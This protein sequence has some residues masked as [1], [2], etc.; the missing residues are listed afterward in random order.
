MIK[1]KFIFAIETHQEL[2]ADSNAARSDICSKHHLNRDR[3]R[4]LSFHDIIKES[5]AQKSRKNKF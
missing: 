2:A 5:A 4:S 3:L 1:R